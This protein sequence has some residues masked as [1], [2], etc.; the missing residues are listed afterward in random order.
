MTRDEIKKL[1]DRAASLVEHRRSSGPDLQ[2]LG[3]NR[4]G[5]Q[6]DE[7]VYR[8]IIFFRQLAPSREGR[9]TRCRD[10]RVLGRPDGFKTAGFECRRQLAGRHRTV[11]EEHGR[12]E[13]HAPPP[14]AMRAAG[15]PNLI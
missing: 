15:R 2:G 14:S 6:R 3:R 9:P 12:T 13:I 1:A 4:R 11:G 8:F 7:R 10:M 5:R